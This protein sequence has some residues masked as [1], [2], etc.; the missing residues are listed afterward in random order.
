[1]A[2]YGG[3]LLLDSSFTWS[4]ISNH[5]SPSP[6]YCNQTSRSK[7]LHRWRRSKAY[8]LYMELTSRLDLDF[9]SAFSFFSLISMKTSYKWCWTPSRQPLTPIYRKMRGGG[10]MTARPSELLASSRSNLARPGELV[11]S[12]TTFS[13]KVTI[14]PLFW[15]FCT[16]PPEMS[17]NPSDCA[18]ISVKKVNSADKNPNINQRLSLDE[19]RVWQLPLFAYLLLE[20]K[21]K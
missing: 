6:F 13:P 18:M 10:C 11:A 17:Q 5:L 2:S 4:G 7:R 8:K 15:V 1:M 20:I 19:I 16:F 3:E 21:G 9:S 14:L 12:S